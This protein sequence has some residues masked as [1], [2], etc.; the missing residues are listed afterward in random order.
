MSD[1]GEAAPERKEIY[2]YKAPWNIYGMNWSHKV[3]EI[4][5]RCV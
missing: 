1:E 3:R 2:S 4:T 5:A